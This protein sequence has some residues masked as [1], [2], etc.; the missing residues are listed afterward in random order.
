MASLGYHLPRPRWTYIRVHVALS[1]M[2]PLARP[3][4]WRGAMDAPEERAHRVEAREA[5]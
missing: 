4:G 3:D 2:A 5:R 1:E